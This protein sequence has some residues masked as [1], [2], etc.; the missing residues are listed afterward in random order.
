MR[1]R[2]TLS[3]LG[4]EYCGWQR[5]KNGVSVQQKVEEA[6]EKLL[7]QK[8]D[9]QASG[10]TDAGVH[11]AGQV[12]HF[13][14]ETSIPSDKLPFALNTLLPDDVR[15]RD[16]EETSADFHARF[17]AKR[18][19]YVYKIYL[20][21]HSDPLRLGRAVMVT[22]PFDAEKARQAAEYFKGRH[23]FKAFCSTG[24]RVKD[25]VREIYD[26]SVMQNGDEITLSVTGNG[27]LY[28]M[29]RI[30]A[31][32]VVYAGKGKIAA[33]AVPDIINSG[34]RKKAGKTMPACGLY[35]YSVEYDGF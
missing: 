14:A 1:Y 19:T 17:S 21:R 32:T 18:K 6:L 33:E 20:A 23:D 22:P 10:R 15:V 26:I 9:V 4:T 28:N 35:L 3:Y 30:I 24:S 8:I 7:G 29:V 11:A 34:D 16:C 31:G 5:Q 27:F 25:T 13:D 12:A 2:I